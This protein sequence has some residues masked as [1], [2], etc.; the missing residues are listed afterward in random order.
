MKK[1]RRWLLAFA[2]IIALMVRVDGLKATSL[3]FGRSPAS[4]TTTSTT[5]SPSTSTTSTTAAPSAHAGSARH[6]SD[7]AS[8]EEEPQSSDDQGDD[9]ATKP[10]LT[11]IPQIDYVW[12]P[13]LPREL[14]GANLSSYPF[15]DSVPVED[16]IGFTCDPKLHD[17]FYASIKYNCQLYHHCVNGVRYDFL[18]ANYTAF[19]QKTF[20]C[21]FASEV[22]CKNSPKYW[23]R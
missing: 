2:V 23:F 22:D 1:I 3:I 6:L 13:N 11:G 18:C 21:H 5:S 19:D 17:G 16:E 10:P 7:D 20:I 8:D 14:R 9:G 15:L 12:D 4:T